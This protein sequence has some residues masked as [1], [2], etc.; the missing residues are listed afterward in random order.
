MQSP[1]DKPTGS[2]RDTA[3]IFETDTRAYRRI[4]RA[5]AACCVWSSKHGAACRA[6]ADSSAGNRW[7]RIGAG[8]R[9]ADQRGHGWGNH[10]RRIDD[11]ARRDARDR[12]RCKRLFGDAKR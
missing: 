10:H 3:I 9:R 2:E 8:E 12:R 7:C 11:R 1:Y 6:A 4:G 5:G